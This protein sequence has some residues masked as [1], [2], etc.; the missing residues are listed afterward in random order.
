MAIFCNESSRFIE[1]IAMM[2]LKVSRMSITNRKETFPFV[3]VV[4]KLRNPRRKRGR[5][6]G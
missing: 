4:H 2:D 3:K 6:L 5:L 1:V